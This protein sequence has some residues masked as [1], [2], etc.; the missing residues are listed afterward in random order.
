MPSSSTFAE[1][2]RFHTRR[3]PLNKIAHVLVYAEFESE[4]K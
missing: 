4:S 3:V 2:F 1:V